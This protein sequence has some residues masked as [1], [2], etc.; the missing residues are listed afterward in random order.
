LTIINNQVQCLYQDHEQ[1]RGDAVEQREWVH[2]ETPTGKPSA[3][4]YRTGCRCEE[5]QVKYREYQ[6]DWRRNRVALATDG[7]GAV[8]HHCHKGPPSPRTAVRWGCVHPR[9]LEL[10]GL[11]VD[12]AGMVRRAGSSVA[13]PNFGA[14]RGDR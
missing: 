10:A 1:E 5:C 8:Q 13:A 11:V 12:D 7:E 4:A 14:A 3:A 6:R 9:C 2:T